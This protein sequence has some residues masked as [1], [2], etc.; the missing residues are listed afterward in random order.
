MYGI[1]IIMLFYAL[2]NAISWLINGS[3]PGSVIGMVLLFLALQFKIVNPERIKSTV[4]FF[5]KNMA[6]FYVPV[7]VGIIAN[8]H[9]FEG[10][11]WAIIISVILSTIIVL[12]STGYLQQ[13][14]ER[15][16]K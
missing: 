3:F 10:N 14:I 6:L 5:M 12:L 8:Y 4:R 16:K 9:L 2:G 11:F 7:G 15:W 13:T 1:F